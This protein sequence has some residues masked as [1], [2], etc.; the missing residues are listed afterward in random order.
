MKLPSLLAFS[1]LILLMILLLVYVS[2]YRVKIGPEQ[3]IH[4]SHRVHVTD[5]HISCLMCH[6]GAAMTKQADIP[7]V[8]TCMLCHERII[9]RHPE[10]QK[11]HRH[12]YVN[13][14]LAWNRV[15]EKLPDFVYFNHAVHVHKNVDCGSCHG[16][17]KAMD[18]VEK[19]QDFTMGFCIRCHRQKNAGI[20]CYRCHR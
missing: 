7:P 8:Q 14:P 10:I 13:E 9:V 1:T 17:I 6:Q 11:L 4:F 18:R 20:D 16:N 19:V 12:F 15:E 2:F 3:P 5:K